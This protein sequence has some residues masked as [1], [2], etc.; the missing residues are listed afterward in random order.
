MGK[1]IILLKVNGD[2]FEVTV[3]PQST[4]LD[5]LRDNLGFT[6]T[7]K[8][9]QSGACGVCTVIIDGKAILSCMT[10]ALDW[11]G[12]SITTIE[13]ISDKGNLHP[14][15]KSFIDNGAIQCGFCSPGI[16]MTAKSL[17]DEIPDPDDEQINEAMA[18]TF[19]RCTGHIKIKEAVKKT[20]GSDKKETAGGS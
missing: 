7:K 14:I 15:Q 4:L 18:G 5:V 6:G 8:G 1:K 17:L 2:Q 19:C 3:S 13:G 12:A 11:E 10:L 16:I 9:C 20:A